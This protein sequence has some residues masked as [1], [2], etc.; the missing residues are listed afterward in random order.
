MLRLVTFLC[1]LRLQGCSAV[2]AVFV[3]DLTGNA[4]A[5][6]YGVAPVV[7]DDV[8]VVTTER[9]YDRIYRHA[10]IT[11]F[12]IHVI[13]LAQIRAIMECTD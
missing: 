9:V 8:A 11:Q 12:A 4:T 2:R 10:C 7:K 5:P 3:W 6:G 1:L 13:V